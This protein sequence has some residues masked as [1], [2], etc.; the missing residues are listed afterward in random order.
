MPGLEDNVVVHKKSKTSG[1]NFGDPYHGE[2]QTTD[3]ERPSIGESALSL[4]STSTITL[5][6]ALELLI[7]TP[8]IIKHQ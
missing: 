2:G 5:S 1:T 6:P 8:A 7:D 3:G 4:N